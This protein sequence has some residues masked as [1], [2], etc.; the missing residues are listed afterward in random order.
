M[1]V[2]V[3]NK[4]LYLLPESYNELITAE[5]IVIQIKSLGTPNGVM[6]IMSPVYPPKKEE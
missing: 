1:K 2:E 4:V 6:S 5:W 3:R